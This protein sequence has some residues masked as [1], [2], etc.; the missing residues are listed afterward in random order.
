MVA[1]PTPPLVVAAAA[2]LAA[3]GL[4]A[5]DGF[6]HWTVPASGPWAV[7]GGG[8]AVLSRA[9]VYDAIGGPASTT[10]LL[11]AV[12]VVAAATW[13]L[14][15]RVTADREEPRRERYLVATGTG[16][17]AVLV[18][19]LFVHAGVSAGRLVW[20]LVAPIA[21]AVSATVGFLALGF[22]RT[23]LLTDLRFSGLYTVGAVVFEGTASIVARDRFAAGEAGLLESA[24]A[25]I[26]TDLTW[27]AAI[28][29]H[30]G[31][32]LAIVVVSGRLSRW[33]SDAGRAAVFVVSVVTLW[34]GTVVVLAAVT[35]G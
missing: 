21:A 29:V 14:V 3:V 9:G 17:S 31:A 23:S 30:L 34:S 18:V 22:L 6:T 16:M 4:A 25:P 15:G 8:V 12:A 24:L 20:V 26:A 19:A 28:P 13:F 5:T 1:Q 32:G 27:W 33:R 10:S 7:G 11:S 2:A 35:F